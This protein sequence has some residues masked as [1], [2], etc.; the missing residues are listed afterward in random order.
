MVDLTPTRI[1]ELRARADEVGPNVQVLALGQDLAGLLD[2]HE[3]R[4]RLR[5]RLRELGADGPDWLS[6]AE[7]R[8]VEAA[9]KRAEKA[10]A[11]VT[12]LTARV[13][14]CEEV[15]NVAQSIVSRY[16]AAGSYSVPC[17]NGPAELVQAVCALRALATPAT[18]EAAPGVTFIDAGTD[19]VLSAVVA[20]LATCEA[21]L[22]SVQHNRVCSCYRLGHPCD[23]CV[24]GYDEVDAALLGTAKTPEELLRDAVPAPEAAHDAGVLRQAAAALDA[25]ERARND[26]EQYATASGVAVALMRLRAR[27]DDI[28]RGRAV[29]RRGTA[30][31]G[32]SDE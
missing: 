13:G 5:D 17:G 11:E 1:A 15:V 26:P 19:P 10:E 4:D 18:P 3:E 14:A 23:R 6:P 22:E 12:R 28:E 25:E 21:A 9:M 29:T 32:G 16:L 8:L 20:R 7:R 30:T 27:A 31:E 2:A 24:V